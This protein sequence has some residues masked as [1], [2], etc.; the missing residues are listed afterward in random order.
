[1]RRSISVRVLA[2]VFVVA[3]AAH[4]QGPRVYRDRVEPH[5]SADGSRFWYRVDDRDGRREFFVVDAAAGTRR[6]ALDGRAF[7][8]LGKVL[9]TKIEPAKPPIDRLDFTKENALVVVAEGRRL[10]LDDKSGEFTA[11]G[12]EEARES[13]LPALGRRPRPSRR[14]GEETR[15]TVVNALKDPVKL[16][17]VDTEGNRR[18]YAVIPP[19]E[20]VE[21]HT[22]GGHVWLAADAGGTI[23]GVYEATDAPATIV[24]D[25]KPATERPLLG[26]N[27]RRRNRGD[28]PDDATHGKRG[29]ISPDG[30]RSVFIKDHDLYLRD[31]E[32]K[33]ESRLSDDGREGDSYALNDVW[34]SPDGK[35]VVALRTEAPQDHPVHI[36]ESSPRDRVQPKLKTIDYLKPGDRIAHPRPK[37]FR[38]DEKKATPVKED[39]FPEPW[40][41]DSVRWSADSSRFT[42]LYNERGHAVLRVVAVDARTGEARAIVDER[43]PTFVCYSGK[44][45]CEWLG[46]DEIVWMSERS[47]WNHLWLIDAKTGEVKNP[48]TSGAWVV[49]DV[50]GVDRDRRR[51]HFRAGGIREGQDP[52]YTH[53]ARVN[54]DGSGLVVPTDGDGTHR[55]EPSPDGKYL[56]D[57]Y[58][59][60][61]MPTITELRRAEDGGL[62]CRLEE[63]DDSEV[64]AA[65][66]GRR[67]ERFVAKGRDGETDIHGIIIRPRDFDPAKRYPVVE[68]IYAGPQ[69]FFTPKAYR[70]DHGTMSRLADLGMIVVQC[71]GMGTSGRSKAFHDVCW[72]NLKDAGLPDRIAWMKAAAAKH[73]EM[74]LSRVGIYGGSAGG[75]NALGALLF[76]GDFYKVAVADCG[77]HDNRMDKI[78]WNEQWMGKLGPH[79][80]ENSNVTHAGKLAGKLMLVVGELDTNVDPAS[81]L[82]VAGALQKA[83]KDF[84]LL[85]VV[86]AGHG[87]AET[88]YGSRRRAEFLKRHL[89]GP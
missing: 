53:V 43:S 26:G 5:W 77:C 84:E 42:F 9:E 69:A 27:G 23:L 34:W 4:A 41:L 19:G 62:V 59:R 61:D 56:I 80:A 86:G 83:D 85:I 15:L 31:T 73:P 7:E 2:F 35:A 14:T 74:D 55:V 46:D 48:I 8:A 88:P 78:W 64:V 18:N 87:A 81:T 50:E 28:R 37:L 60:V 32:S 66:G 36:V 40:S 70:P 3:A 12:T 49:Q 39:L 13:S 11:M 68:Q 76:H 65:R 16:D 45:F 71:D 6:P 63:A 79:Y 82:Q 75:Q 29:P 24:V 47:G 57:A 20:R 21:Q 54:L 51:V 89:I 22:Y 17:W 67:P 1:M 25:G 52:Y 33:E 10:R 58:S 30:K 38:I 72:K 44:F